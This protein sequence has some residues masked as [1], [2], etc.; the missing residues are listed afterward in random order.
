[1]E[2]SL[3]QFLKEEKMEGDNK[4]YCNIC[5]M[6][7]ETTS[8]YYFKRLPQILTFQLK[9]FEFD[10]NYMAFQKIT[11]CITFP[12]VLEFTR[13][14]DVRNEWCRKLTVN[15]MNNVDVVKGKEIP[16]QPQEVKQDHSVDITGGNPE[17]PQGEKVCLQFGTTEEDMEV[18]TIMLKSNQTLVT[19]TILMM[20]ML[21]RSE[22]AYMLMYRLIDTN[23]KA[24]CN[25][26]GWKITAINPLTTNH[27][28]CVLTASV[29]RY[30]D[31]LLNLAEV[32]V[33]DRR[34]EDAKMRRGGGER[35]TMQR[36]GMVEASGGERR[37]RS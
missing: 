12:L 32:R 10:Y 17:T 4:C 6:K 18:A 29:G 25:V 21:K 19:G 1:M 24:D 9:R 13:S 34:R 11:D 36:R 28:V 7:T 33:D 14:Q 16:A 15:R 2:K 22:T 37:R 27:S 35:R 31:L 26:N 5:D 23:P 20:K 8:R 30:S 3:E